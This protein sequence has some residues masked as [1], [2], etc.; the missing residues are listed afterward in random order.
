MP[1]S[2][3]QNSIISDQLQKE[4]ISE[5]VE[6]LLLQYANDVT[7]T[8]NL[9]SLIPKIVDKQLRITKNEVIDYSFATNLL[10]GECTKK[11]KVDFQTMLHTSK[12][13]FPEG[14]C[15]GA[16]PA[17]KEFFQKFVDAI[18]NKKGFDYES[19][20]DWYFICKIVECEEWMLS[21]IRQ[22]VDENYRKELKYASLHNNPLS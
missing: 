9:L 15:E 21:V 10:I 22:N 18:K 20:D 12:V 13:C 7:R 14:N 3:T 2:I 1:L 11:G 8:S 19:E 4:N 6:T 5:F 16:C 17:G